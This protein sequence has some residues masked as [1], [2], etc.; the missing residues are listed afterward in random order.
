[1]NKILS[2]FSGCG[3]LDLGF[4]KAGFHAVLATD[5]WNIACKSLEL[6]DVADT[7]LC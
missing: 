2:L 1:M 7:I 6:N 3:G 4:R 5:V